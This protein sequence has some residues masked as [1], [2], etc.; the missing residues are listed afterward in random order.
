MARPR[1]ATD[2]EIYQAAFQIMGR[3]GPTEWTLDD[4]ATEVGL[5]PSAL[6]QRFG[7]K[8]QLQLNLIRLYAD[9]V[10]QMYAALRNRQ[11]SPLGAVRAWAGQVACLAESPEALAH[12]LDYLRLDLTDPDMHVHFRRQAEAGRSFLREALMEAVGEGDLPRDTD[13]DTLTRLVETS[14]TGSLFTWATYRE[15]TAEEWVKR[16]LE[17][18]LQHPP[19]R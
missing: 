9:H 1:K 16:D 7:S 18:V 4:V 6:V 12:H 5:T 2:E 8:R 19:K 11:D 13:V 10:P 14:V 15:G 3:R 17:L